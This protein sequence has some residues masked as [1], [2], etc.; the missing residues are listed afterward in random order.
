MVTISKTRIGVLMGGPSSEREISLKSGKAVYSALRQAGLEAV[1]VDITTDS[2]QENSKLLRSEKIDFAFLSL[3]G[4]FGEDGCIQR[5]LEELKIPYTGSGIQASRMAFDKAASRRVFSSGG[6]QVPKYKVIASN[7]GLD[8]ADARQ[9]FCAE[10]LAGFPF[11]LVVKPAAQGSSI[12]LSLIDRLE[13][14]GQGLD[15][16]FQRDTKVIVEEYVSGR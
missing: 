10:S 3:H 7:P 5:L 14:L 11:P 2:A 8:T 13:G 6:L 1:P 4:R 12:G 9:R 16:A 15:L